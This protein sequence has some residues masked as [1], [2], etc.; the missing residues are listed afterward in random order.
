M[1]SSRSRSPGI[2]SDVTATIGSAARS[3]PLAHLA[4][5]RLAA[6]ARDL[7]VE[8][9]QVG[10]RRRQ[11]GARLVDGRRLHHLVPA[12][13]PGCRGI[14]S[15]LSGLSSTIRMRAGA[16]ARSEAE[17]SSVLLRH[18]RI[19]RR[20]TAA[21]PDRNLGSMQVTLDTRWTRGVGPSG[22]IMGQE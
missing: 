19:R 20:R 2:A 9:Q 16:T 12:Q 4:D 3:A 22:A 8:Q 18:L 7:H 15:R 10:R 14:S 13:L 6:A 17:Y 1:L 21:W 11:H 5:D